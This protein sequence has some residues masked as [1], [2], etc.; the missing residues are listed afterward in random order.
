MCDDATATT[1]LARGHHDR[2]GHPGRSRR[3]TAGSAAVAAERQRRCPPACRPRQLGQPSAPVHSPRR[4]TQR[5][6]QLVG[7]QR[8]SG[9]RR[10][11]H[12][13]GEHQL[14]APAGTSASTGRPA[15]PARR[16]PRAPPTA[17]ARA[18]RK[19]EGAGTERS[20]CGIAVMTPKSGQVP[21]TTTAPLA[22]S[23][24]TAAPSRRADGADAVERGDVVGA[25]HDDRRVRRRARRRTWRRPG[26]TAP[27]TSRRR[28]PWCS[29]GSACPTA[30]PA[31]G[32]SARRAPRR[33]CRQP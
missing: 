15:A 28:S 3:R 21:T 26:P 17:C 13:L 4:M 24:R 14:R 8:I 19:P 6:Q 2:C 5:G 27:S 29:T 25:D 32:R 11:E 7:G 23:R 20:G 9:R 10:M 16:R 33:R 12:V 1:N 31:R 22:R 30:R 18:R